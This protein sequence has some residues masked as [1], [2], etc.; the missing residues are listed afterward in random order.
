M[1]LRFAG[2]SDGAAAAEVAAR[3][4]VRER[5][6]LVVDDGAKPGRRA[7]ALAEELSRYGL[8]ARTGTVPDGTPLVVAAAGGQ[9]SG[10]HLVV[11][12]E[13]DADPTDWAAVLT[14]SGVAM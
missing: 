14:G 6:E 1:V 11:R 8:S 13:H 3:L 5:V 4:A 7:V 2:G 10:A 12:A 9:T